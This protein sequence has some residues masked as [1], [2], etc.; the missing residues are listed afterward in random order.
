[1]HLLGARE[2]VRRDSRGWWKAGDEVWRHL[3]RVRSA[4]AKFM[5]TLARALN[6][7]VTLVEIAIALGIPT[8]LSLTASIA[9]LFRAHGSVHIGN[10]QITSTIAIEVILAS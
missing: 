2:A 4:I 9:W 6:R 7:P 3:R 5:T 1:E 8:A 10:A